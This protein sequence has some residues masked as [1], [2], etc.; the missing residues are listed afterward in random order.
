MCGY[1]DI[2]LTSSE[3][4]LRDVAIWRSYMPDDGLMKRKH[5]VKYIIYI[6]SGVWP[7]IYE[8]LHLQDCIIYHITSTLRRT[9]FYIFSL[10][11]KWEKLDASSV[12]ACLIFEVIRYIHIKCSLCSLI[13]LLDV[14]QLTT[15]RRLYGSMKRQPALETPSR[16][17]NP[18]IVDMNGRLEIRDLQMWY[19]SELLINH[20]AL[21]SASYRKYIPYRLNPLK[22]EFIHNYIYKFSSYLTGNTL[23]LRYKVQPVNVVWGNSRCLLWEPYGTH[24]Y[25]LWA[26][27]RVLMC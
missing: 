13:V 14:L 8:V 17:R 12:R 26:E 9:F 16:H 4:I 22:T 11:K 19:Q 20:Y 7:M 24:R 1:S 3:V 6:L 18:L 15:S 27:C 5:F 23:H 2:H 21:Y 10:L 25:T